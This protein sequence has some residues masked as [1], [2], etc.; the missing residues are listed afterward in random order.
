MEIASE[1]TKKAER[2]VLPNH[3][4]IQL[5]DLP[6]NTPED[7]LGEIATVAAEQNF[8]ATLRYDSKNA[9]AFE[10]FSALYN[11]RGGTT[12]ELFTGESPSPKVRERVQRTQAIDHAATDYNINPA[13]I[14]HLLYLGG[15]TAKKVV[16]IAG[17]FL[18]YDENDVHREL[19]LWERPLVIHGPVS[20]TFVSAAQHDAFEKLSKVPGSL[21]NRLIAQ[22]HDKD[23]AFTRWKL[24]ASL[25]SRTVTIDELRSNLAAQP[26]TRNAA[27]VLRGPAS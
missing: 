12:L 21:A 8:A 19:V 4:A 24:E 15:K 23:L 2:G 11:A 25:L 7:L 17:D 27:Q 18:Q 3:Q 6:I 13:R 10:Q 9:D 16:A 5:P 1:T 26:L 22:E 14:G 20:E